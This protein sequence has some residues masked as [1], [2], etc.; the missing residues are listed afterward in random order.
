[1]IEILQKVS[2]QVLKVEN[3]CSESMPVIEREYHTPPISHTRISIPVKLNNTPNLP[4]FSGQEPVQ[5]T[6]GS[7]D[8]WLFQ[9]EGALATHMEKAVRLAVIESV[10]GAAHELL[11]FIG[12][13]KEMDVIIRHI[14]VHFGQGSSKAKLPKEFFAMEQEKSESINQFTGKS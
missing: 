5:S 8:Q 3:M 7:I 4:M 10:R 14:K 1:M 11:E 12:Y 9:M 2:D 6:E 13:G